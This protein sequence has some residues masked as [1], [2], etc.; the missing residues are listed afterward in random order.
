MGEKNFRKKYI[1]LK[2]KV[3]N[4]RTCVSNRSENVIVKCVGDFFKKKKPKLYLFKASWCGQ[5]NNLKPT[6]D[7]IKKKYKKNCEFIEIDADEDRDEM[8]EWDPP[9]QVFPTVYGVGMDDHKKEHRGAMYDL[10]KFVEEIMEGKWDHEAEEKEQQKGIQ[11]IMK[12]QEEII[13]KKD[14][15][16]VN[17]HEEHHD[18]DYHD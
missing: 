14:K 11:E 13:K 8:M 4:L 1:D 5:C 17:D 9:I 12:D 6:W 2:N 18:H 7:K 16:E 3:S 15:H 10:S